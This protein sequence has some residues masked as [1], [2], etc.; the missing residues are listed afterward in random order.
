MQP[1]ADFTIANDTRRQRRHQIEEITRKAGL[2]NIASIGGVL[3]QFRC[4][5]QLFGADAFGRANRDV[6]LHFIVDQGVN[7]VRGYLHFLEIVRFHDGKRPGPRKMHEKHIIL[8][9]ISEERISRQRA[10]TKPGHKSVAGISRPNFLATLPPLRKHLSVVT[11]HGADT[12]V[13]IREIGTVSLIS[14]AS[15][16]KS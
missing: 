11:V 7:Q 5:F 8:A 2:E 13:T 10:I 4:L 16:R 3:R 14:P 1:R 12:S 6:K 9:K 15:S